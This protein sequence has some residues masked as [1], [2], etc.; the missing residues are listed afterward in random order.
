MHYEWSNSDIMAPFASVIFSWI[1][2]KNK[3]FHTDTWLRF[4]IFLITCA[5][6]HSMLVHHLQYSKTPFSLKTFFFICQLSCSFHEVPGQTSVTHLSKHSNLLCLVK[7][8]S[9][10]SSIKEDRKIKKNLF[11]VTV[12][13][14]CVTYHI[15]FLRKHMIFLIKS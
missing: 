6:A 7:S 14:F 8:A 10:H 13:R 3:L 11:P 9:A 12:V 5:I 4:H 1:L 15:L 2:H